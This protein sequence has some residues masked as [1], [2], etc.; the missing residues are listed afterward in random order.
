MVSAL[1]FIIN[2]AARNTFAGKARYL[3]GIFMTF[4]GP[5]P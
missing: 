1:V 2:S 4:F 3:L 5:N